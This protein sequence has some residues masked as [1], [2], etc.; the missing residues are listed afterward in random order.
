MTPMDAAAAA[1][2]LAEYGLNPDAATT[3][4]LDAAA[5]YAGLDRPDGPEDRHLIREA[6]SRITT[7]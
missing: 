1:L 6:L 7:A 5:D 4:D 3:A 2:V